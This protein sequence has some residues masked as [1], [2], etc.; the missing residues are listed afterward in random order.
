MG[1]RE[2]GTLE[3]REQEVKENVKEAQG[4]G[5]AQGGVHVIGVGMTC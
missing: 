2:G 4:R 5:A 1:G 3:R